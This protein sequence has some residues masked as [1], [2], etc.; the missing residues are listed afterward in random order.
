[1]TS[2]EEIVSEVE[3]LP[4]LPDTVL[5]VINVINNPSS[6]ID[7]IVDAVKYDQAITSE[8]LRLCNSAY[9]GVVRKVTSLNDALVVL[10]NVKL[11]QMVMAVHTNSLL[12]Q[13]Q[14]GYGLAPGALWKQSV[15]VAIASSALAARLQIPNGNMLFTAGLLHDIGKMVLNEHVADKFAELVRRVAEDKIS[16]AEAEQQV[17]G[18]SHEEVGAMVGEKWHLPPEIIQCIKYHHAPGQLD[19][20]D[21]LVDVV[22]LANC[23]CMIFGIGLGEDG[24]HYRA[25]QSVMERHG[26]RESDIEEVGAETLVE[27]QRIEELF[28]RSSGG[29]TALRE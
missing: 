12:S 24:L 9:F 29:A 8:I 28:S 16:F 6:T 23:T 26:L 14:S 20:P 7:Q 1:M 3:A 27:L 10:G 4:P 21:P 17:L 19:P 18:F 5:K 22:Y 13:G 11:L 2:V 15:A 25:D